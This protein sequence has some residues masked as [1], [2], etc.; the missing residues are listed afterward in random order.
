MIE[1]DDIDRQVAA[2]FAEDAGDTATDYL[3]AID[4]RVERT[5]QWPAWATLPTWRPAGRVLRRLDLA[6]AFLF[7]LLLA[8]LLVAIVAAAVGGGSGP[9]LKELTVV[10]APSESATARPSD[11][12]RPWPESARATQ[13]EFHGRDFYEVPRPLAANG[14][15]ALVYVQL[16]DTMSYARIYRVLYHSRT[17]SDRDIAVSGTIWVPAASP[18]VGGYPIVAFAMDN[19]GSGDLC[20][21][22]RSEPSA[23]NAS[24]G[25]LISLLLEEGYVVAH[26][27]YEGMGTTD[28]YPFAVNESAAHAMLDSARAARDLLAPNVSDRVVLFGHGLGGDAATTAGEEA[29]SYAPD[30]DVRGVGGADGG[31]GDHATALRNFVAAGAS[32]D[33]PTVL[34]QAVSGYSVAFPE[35]RPDDVLTPLGLEDIRFLDSTCWPQFN[36]LVSRQ[37]ATDVLAVNPLDV[38]RW[39]RRIASMTVT[40]APHPTLLLATGEPKPDSDQ[41]RA[42]ERLCATSDDVLLLT[43]P[44]AMEGAR[45]LGNDPYMG[46]YVVSWPDARPWIAD[47]FAGVRAPGNCAG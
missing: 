27:D 12:P 1:R 40:A 26:T 44:Q 36:G 8:T 13:L 29:Q 37:R 16:I 15:G 42:A 4:G 14:A 45:D 2:W 22:S 11:A 31:G 6:P 46:V 28:P 10:P 47:R 7:L 35:L 38:P 30:L 17:V 18:P 32:S 34:L 9:R 21:S 43:Y 19:E 23:I 20:A 25:S 41:F 24:Y 39:A 5:R 3:D 33:P